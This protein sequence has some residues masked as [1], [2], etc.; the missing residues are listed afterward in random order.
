MCRKIKIIHSVSEINNSWDELANSYYLKREFLTHLHNFNYCDQ[1]YYE[2]YKGAKFVTGTLVYTLKINLLT[3]SGFNFP[4]RMSV[5]GLPVSIASPP[6]IGDINEAEYLLKEIIKQERGI[7]LGLNFTDDYLNNIVVNLRAL[8]TIVMK[9]KFNSYEDYLMSMRHSYR[10][11]V[12]HDQIKFK[13]IRSTELGCN[14]FTNEH[15]LLYLEIMKRTKTKLEV[16]NLQFF[17]NLPGNF[18]L[19]THYHNNLMLA[20]QICTVDNETLYFFFGGMDY[21]Y[22]DIYNLYYNNLQSIVKFGLRNNI[23]SIDF[24]QTAEVAKMRLGGII[25]E[26]RMFLFHKNRIINKLFKLFSGLIEYSSQ[27]ISPN[28]FHLKSYQSKL[29]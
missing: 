7:I 27:D 15:Y 12:K 28:V 5:I 29:N 9:E 1:R 10:R 18:I 23:R 13:D 24:G 6:I 26:R 22:R 14:T 2:L 17:Q 16:L 11:K 20:W 8:P 25:N 19:T 4:I 3:F 21:R